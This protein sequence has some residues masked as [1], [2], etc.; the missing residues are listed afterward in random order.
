MNLRA[1]DIFRIL[2]IVTLFLLFLVFLFKLVGVMAWLAAALLITILLSPLVDWIQ[3]YIPRKNRPTAVFITFLLVVLVFVLL[4]LIILPP[5]YKELAAMLSATSDSVK[6]LKDS[7]QFHAYYAQLGTAAGQLPTANLPEVLGTSLSRL[8]GGLTGLIA[9]ISSGVF[10]LITIVTLTFFM[11]LDTQSMIENVGRFVNKKY[12]NFYNKLSTS[13]FTI[14]SKYFTG[15]VIVAALAGM[16]AFVPLYLTHAP[17][18][19]A[20]AFTIAI[21]DLIPMVGATIGTIVVALVCLLSGNVTAAVTITVFIVIYQQIENNVVI[22]L[23][24]KQTVKM[25]PLAIL[26]ALLIGGAIGGII[27]TLLA[28]PAAAMIKV[29]Y[30]EAKK[31]GFLG[32]AN[33]EEV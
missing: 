8:R 22:P 20:L 24:Q 4:G 23:V 21:F 28:I 13:L 25:T 14:V 16:A 12:R 32:R 10:I 7:P 26:I 3:R 33:V 2:G 11:L 30:I 6:A 31:E 29:I 18:A 17:Y 15:V 19:I 1:A 27:G 5:L 9:G